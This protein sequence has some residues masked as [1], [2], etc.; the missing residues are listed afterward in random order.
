MSRIKKSAYRLLSIIISAMLSLFLAIPAFAQ[1]AVDEPGILEAPKI[2]KVGAACVYNV[3]NDRFIFEHNADKIVYPA[4]TVKL[5]TAIV[6]LEEL[7]FEL[8]R[9]ITV[10]GGA[11]VGLRGNNIALKRNEILTL[12]QL[13]YALVCGGA[14]DAANVL[15]FEVAGSVEAFVMLMNKKAKELGAL[16]T[17]YLNPTGM[18]E[19]DMVTT[20]KDTAIIATYAAKLSPILEMS[21]VE[22][23]VIPPTNKAGTRTL[24]NKNC[25]FSS[26]VEYLYIWNIPRGLNAGYTEE[27]GNC[28]VTTATRDGLTYIVVI[29]DALDDGEYIYS[30][31]EAADLIKWAF[32]A[33]DYTSVLTTSNMICEI[34]VR[35]S[36]SSDYVTLFP[37]ENVELY[38]P[39]GID[40]SKDIEL[41]WELDSEY[42]VAP[43]SEGQV[44][45]RISVSYNGTSLGEY[46]LVT[47]S[48]V[49][50]NNFL[51]ILDLA[52]DVTRTNGFR[53]MI[54]IAA[55]IA[56]AYLVVAIFVRYNRTSRKKR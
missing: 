35:L 1:E 26:Y 32:D 7:N 21:S 13:L 44:G 50:R 46:D 22:K 12:E 53:T 30:Y 6:A 45:G 33:Y 10:P 25:Y 9:E 14:N 16:N 42:M 49:N 56:A 18:H 17:H 43:I 48:S 27:G 55:F 34:P 5:M 19:R 31:T 4:S 40:V 2:E 28:L 37:S 24:F 3:E 8:D 47:R 29:L 51:Y 11:L 54:G 20:A 39:V 41:K 23:Y 36:A 38:L 52:A 15:A